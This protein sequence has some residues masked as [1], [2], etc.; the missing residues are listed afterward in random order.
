MDGL[1][2]VGDQFGGG[3]EEIGSDAADGERLEALGDGGIPGEAAGDEEGAAVGGADV[4]GAPLGAGE[5]LEGAGNVEGDAEVA[6]EAVAAAGGDDAEGGGGADQ[7]GADAVDHA[8]A[9]G[10]EHGV[11]AV[12][13]GAFG[14]AAAVGD[15]MAELVGDVGLGAEVFLDGAPEG[16]ERGAEA[17]FRVHE[18]AHLAAVAGWGSGFHDPGILPRAGGKRTCGMGADGVFHGVEK[19]C[20]SARG[21]SLARSA[22]RFAI[23]LAFARR[24]RLGL[25]TRLFSI[26]WKNAQKVFHGVEK[27]PKSFPWRGK[28]RRPGGGAGRR[29]RGG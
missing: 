11:D 6:G 28:S 22:W 26:A 13:D 12:A 14:L 15:V 23:D 9:A 21:A 20:R 2:L 5:G 8:V 17:R 7:F 19:S 25:G 1:V 16:I 24:L 4:D 18:H 27:R 10:D 3:G 29:K